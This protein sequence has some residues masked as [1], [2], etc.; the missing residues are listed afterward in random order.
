MAHD[1]IPSILYVDDEQENLDSF[2]LVFMGDYD[3]YLANSAKEG[4]IIL[5]KQ[6]TKSRPIQLVIS[7]HKMPETTGIEFLK[8]LNKEYPKLAKILLT[9]FSD[10]QTIKE[11]AQQKVLCLSKPWIEKELK[12]NI[13]SVLQF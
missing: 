13:D 9:G 4:L 12:D 2:Q 11:A 5:K 8:Q 3:I 6:V 1:N 7:D 10:A